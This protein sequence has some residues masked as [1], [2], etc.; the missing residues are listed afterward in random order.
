MDITFIL[1]NPLLLI[2]LAVGV[3]MAWGIGAN[4]VANAVGTSVG[5]GALT[6]RRAVIVAGVAEFLGATLAGGQVTETVRNGMVHAEV[7]TD[8]QVYVWGMLAALL[9]A[10]VWLNLAS[11]VGA[12][13]STT[14][15]IVGAVI[16]FGLLVGGLD[17]INLPKV[18]II[19]SSWIISPISGGLLAFFMFR[20]IRKKVLHAPHPTAALYRIA[21]FLIAIVAFVLVLSLIFKGLKN[22]NFDFALPQALIV[23]LIAAIVIGGLA[24][25]VFVYH[26]HRFH[27]DDA[28]VEKVFILLQ[29]VTA[30]YV[31]FAHGA[32]DVANAIGPLAA[33]WDV[34]TTG[35]ISEKVGVP[36]WILLLG[37]GG[38]VLGLATFGWRVIKTIGEKIT[39]ITPSRGFC[40]E[41]GAATTVLVASKLGLPISTTHTL[42]GAVVGV[43]LA[44]GLDALDLAVVKKIALGWIITLP[45]TAGFTI[46]FYYALAALFG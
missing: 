16:G 34:V 24:K 7:F 2:A 27:E 33:V 18:G 19:A 9:A 4:D 1:S 20:F 3:Y 17:A 29:I 10:A 32:N 46:G 21:P 37:G 44:Q 12:P 40:A 8:P 39:A 41:F 26:R 5:S 23:A 25:L 22:L 31:A 43:G 15:S 11:Y 35:V 14:H 13:V 30:A 38:I 45:I 36:F 6:F 42:V 28:H